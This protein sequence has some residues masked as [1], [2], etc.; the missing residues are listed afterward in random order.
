MNTS[1]LPI[2]N[3]IIVSRL[4]L[5]D[6]YF[7]PY[8]SPSS[9]TSFSLGFLFYI[10]SFFLSKL[11]FSFHKQNTYI[12]DIVCII[13]TKPS[14]QNDIQ[15]AFVTKI[16]HLKLFLIVYTDEM[17]LHK[18]CLLNYFFDERQKPM[19]RQANK[20]TKLGL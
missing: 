9:H 17:V 1:Y 12:Q 14:Q 10:F 19:S 16:S 8:H 6:H 15:I 2:K 20:R 18:L 5:S 4:N 3:T 11:I 7:Q 13:L